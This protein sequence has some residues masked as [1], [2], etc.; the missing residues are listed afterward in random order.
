LPKRF[1]LPA[2]EPLTHVYFLRSG[3]V[4]L[5]VPVASG[6]SVEVAAVGR[7]G[8]LGVSLLLE[9]DPPPYEMTCQV[10]GEA[11]CLPAATF[12]QLVQDLPEFRRL[13]MRYTLGLLHEVARTAACSGLHRVEERMARWLLLW[14]DRVGAE[15]FPVTHDALARMLG[16]GRPFVTQTAR[17]LQQ[18]G[19]IRYER[20]VMQIVNPPG[21][22]AVACEDYRAVERHYA[23]LRS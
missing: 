4:C 5:V 20:G 21:L 7:E 10:P 23:L 12:A 3:L 2:G 9:A 11:L 22:E 16:V 13:L 8:M 14:R 15:R 18:A 17:A 1:L 19:L 6:G